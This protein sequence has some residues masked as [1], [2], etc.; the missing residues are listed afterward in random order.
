MQY[1]IQTS[2]TGLHI[3]FMAKK[4]HNIVY[5]GFCFDFKYSDKILY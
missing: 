1:E 4:M 3:Y 2:I 5:A